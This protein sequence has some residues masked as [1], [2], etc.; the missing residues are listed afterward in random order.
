MPIKKFSTFEEASKDLWILEP[1]KEYYKKLKEL[2][3]LWG[4]LSNKKHSKGIQKFKSYDY[5]LKMQRW[6]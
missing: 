1:N 3:A 4:K 6:N 5:L 2:F